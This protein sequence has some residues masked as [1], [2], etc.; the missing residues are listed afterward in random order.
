MNKENKIEIDIDIKKS[1][2]AKEG[3]GDGNKKMVVGQK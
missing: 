2:V 1:K 3:V